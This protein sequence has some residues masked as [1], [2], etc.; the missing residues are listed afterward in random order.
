MFGNAETDHRFHPLI[1]QFLPLFRSEISALAAVFRRLPFGLLSLFFCGKFFF[2][3]KA[4][5]GFSFGQQLVNGRLIDVK[6]FHL[7]V[8]PIVA[9]DV[10]AFIPIHTQPFQAILNIF[11][12]FLAR[13]LQV[14]IFHTNDKSSLMFFCQQIVKQSRTGASD[15]QRPCRA[16]GKSQTVIFHDN[17]SLLYVSL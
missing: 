5:V 4:I 6:A 15:M 7:T 14:R 1:Q 11:L 12:R 17:R 8:R 3:T 13:T 10:N 2:A 9:A 16:R